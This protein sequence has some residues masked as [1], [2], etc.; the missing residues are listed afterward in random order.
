[1]LRHA[2]KKTGYRTNLSRKGNLGPKHFVRPLQRKCRLVVLSEQ[3]GNYS[4]EFSR[5]FGGVY[6][7]SSTV[8]DRGLSLSKK[9]KV[10]I[11]TLAV[12]Q[13]SEREVAA[14][15]RRSK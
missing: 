11:S 6:P 12:E 10:V 3:S 4:K 13:K 2:N 14:R 5:V 9:E 7:P 8:M 1:M 15:V